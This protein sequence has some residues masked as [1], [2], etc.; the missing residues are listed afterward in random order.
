MLATIIKVL[1]G[2][3]SAIGLLKQFGVGISTGSPAQVV[4]NEILSIINDTEADH[5]NYE[6][7]QAVIV[8][9]FTESGVK[10]YLVA[11][12]SGGPAASSLG[13]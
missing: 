8:A 3:A 10:G 1:A 9:T 7:G 4:E 13:L 11:V 2:I 6:N 5:A 12:K